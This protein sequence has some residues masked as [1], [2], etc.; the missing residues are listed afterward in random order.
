MKVNFDA[1]HERHQDDPGRQEGDERDSFY[2][3]AYTLEEV[4]DLLNKAMDEDLDDELG[5]SRV[6]IR[7]VMKKLEDELSPAEFARLASL[8]FTGI[9]T[10]ARLLQAK[11][12]LADGSD[13]ELAS[14]IA[15]GLDEVSRRRGI[16][17]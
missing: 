3:E 16:K 17:L 15:Q 7:R 1:G 11:R 9:N 2:Q 5:A 10:I 6:A 4:A 13:E 12:S 14:V 8:I